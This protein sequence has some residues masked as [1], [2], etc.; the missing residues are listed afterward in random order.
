M[1]YIIVDY[2]GCEVPILFE[3]VIEHSTFNNAF[4]HIV[5]AGECKII[6][7]K[8]ENKE[9]RTVT[10]EFNVNAFGESQSLKLKSRPED[11]EIIWNFIMRPLR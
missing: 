7:T 5:S 2:R 10:N 8:E 11:A 1:K 6:A 4:S 9:C 3:D